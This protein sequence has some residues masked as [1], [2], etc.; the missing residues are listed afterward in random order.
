MTQPFSDFRL[1]HSNA[2][3]VLAALLAKT[4]RENRLHDTMLVPETILIPQPSM[5]RW[6]QIYLAESFGIAANLYCITPGEFVSECLHA[7]LPDDQLPVLNT[8]SMRWRIFAVLNDPQ[9]RAHRALKSIASYFE[10][11]RSTQKAWSL[12]SECAAAFEK[13]QA[14]R[15]DWCLAWDGGRDADDWQAHL[16]RCAVQAKPHRALAIDQYLRRFEASDAIP[17]GLPKRVFAFACSNVSPDV[18]RVIATAAKVGPLHF[19]L[20]SPCKKY[21]GDLQA[22]RSRIKDFDPELFAEEENPLLQQWAYAGRD[23]IATLF[24]NETISVRADIEAYAE[25]PGQSLLAKLQN[26]VLQ[27]HSPE[28][29]AGTL[30]VNDSSLQIHSCHTRLREV[31]VLHDQL[32]RLFIE[33]PTLQPRD[34]AVMAP[35]IQAYAPFIDAVFGAARLSN[36]F[37]PY[38]ISDQ[39]TPVAS[40]ISALFLRFFELPQLHLNSNEVLGLLSHPAMMQALNAEEDCLQWWPNW[41]EQSGAR[42][43][44]NAQHRQQLGAPAEHLSTWAFALDRLLLG[45]ATNSQDPIENIEPVIHVEGQQALAALDALIRGLRMLA[46]YQMQF[47]RA[48]TAEQWATHAARLLN[49]LYGK[50]SDNATEQACKAIHTWI[51]EL[52]ENVDVAGLESSL[53]PEIVQAY[54]KEKFA[55]AEGPSRILSGGVSFCRMVPMRQIPFQMIAVL[56]LNEGEMPRHEPPGMIQRLQQEI[57]STKT[58]RYGDRSLREDDRFLFLQLMMA[59]D[60]V[61]YLSYLGRDAKDNAPLPP[62]PLISELLDV[63]KQMYP[64]ESSL[65]SRLVLQHPL[66]VFS[67]PPSSDSR[68]VYFDPAWHATSTKKNASQII[69]VNTVPTPPETSAIDVQDFLQFFQ[70]PAKYFLRRLCDTQLSSR[71][72]HLLEEESFAADKGL[73]GYQLK[74]AVFDACF[75]Q[76]RFDTSHWLSRFRQQALLPPGLSAEHSL[77]AALKLVYPI[78]QR[79]RAWR[80]GEMRHLDV[81]VSLGNTSIQGQIEGVYANG[82]ERVVLG[83]MRGKHYCQHGIETL[84]LSAMQIDLPLQ[85]FYSSSKKSSLQRTS[86]YIDKD[87]ARERLDHLLSIYHAGQSTALPFLPDASFH[88]FLA[89]TKA[90][91]LQGDFSQS[92]WAKAYDAWP[93]TPGQFKRFDSWCATALRGHDPFLDAGNAVDIFPASVA[94]RQLSLQLFS[95]I[96]PPE[97]DEA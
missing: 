85:E 70:H 88:Y 68:H 31:Q 72:D 78:A 94:F 3:G 57:K 26:D 77:A 39:V 15:R 2:L 47:R 92:A 54:F 60:Q 25:A 74:H 6:L 23:F 87:I 61:F 81:K 82:V 69:A 66:Q 28:I 36:R 37:I 29:Q 10:G 48:Q 16:W 62:S 30:D 42:W 91:D 58:R 96:T 8:E 44:L 33:R 55:S 95:A 12:A 67:P 38:S 35:D 40:S 52:Q 71:F 53:A 93:N 20:P 64:Q 32:H 65:E 5:K 4:M 24:S 7:N 56:G 73:E 80:V 76:D 84:L 9:Q 86:P 1:Y 50:T 41:I 19:F 45:Y 51:V 17:Q 18:L 34:I 79:V 89:C 22:S 13:Y 90:G 83:E 49:T 11:D 75:Q 97:G 63:I 21:W 46:F 59:A 27:R 43:G 14:W